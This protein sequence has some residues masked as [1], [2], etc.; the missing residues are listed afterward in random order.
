MAT[1]VATKEEIMTDFQFQSIIKMVLEIAE[2]KND[3]SEVIRAL[4]KLLPKESV[5]PPGGDR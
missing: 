2:S 4:K 3:V 1:V 5:D